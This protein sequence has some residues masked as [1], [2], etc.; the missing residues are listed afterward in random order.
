[1]PKNSHTRSKSRSES[2]IT[3]SPTA[4]PT[5]SLTANPNITNLKAP[6]I[7]WDK[8]CA[9]RT[10][11]LI[12]WLKENETACLKIFSDS[13]QD[14]KDADRKKE[15]SSHNKNYYYVQAAQAI[16]MNDNNKH[17][18]HFSQVQPKVFIKK[19]NHHIKE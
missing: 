19:I 8:D 13:T 17:V 2:L 12:V 1:M 5:S 6:L 9:V 15:V 7:R 10:T 4:G 3:Q 14:A 11:C 18:Q 16:F